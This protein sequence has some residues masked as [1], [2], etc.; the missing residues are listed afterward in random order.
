VDDFVDAEPP[1]P[2]LAWRRSL[3]LSKA[4]LKKSFSSAFSASA[5]FSLAISSRSCLS[6]RSS[7]LA[8]K[9]RVPRFGAPFQ[10]VLPG[11]QKLPFQLQL[12]R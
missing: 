7:A 6:L 5:D 11:V 8:A 1:V 4:L 3:T 9:F 2:L 10:L 12:A